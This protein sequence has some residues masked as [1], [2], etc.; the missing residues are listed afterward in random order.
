MGKNGGHHV[1]SSSYSE[2]NNAFKFRGNSKHNNKQPRKPQY[3]LVRLC[4]GGYAEF[5]NRSTGN[6]ERKRCKIL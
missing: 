5:R 3:S 6:I 1:P 4:G 2:A